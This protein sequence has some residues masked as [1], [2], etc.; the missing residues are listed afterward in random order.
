MYFMIFLFYYVIL[1]FKSSTIFLDLYSAV[2]LVLFDLL[3][4]ESLLSIMSSFFLFL[5]V[6]LHAKAVK[7]DGLL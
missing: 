7:L 1:W 2:L 5:H 6:S 3:K 4:I